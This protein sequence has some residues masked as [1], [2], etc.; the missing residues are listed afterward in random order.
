[1]PGFLSSTNSKINLFSDQRQLVSK[2]IDR[3]DL[4]VQQYTI[5]KFLQDKIIYGDPN[6]IFLIEGVVFNYNVLL[7]E[8]KTADKIELIKEMYGKEGDAFCN[9][10][11]G[12]FS[13]LFYDIN[14]K[15]LI[16]FTDHIGDKPIFY[17]E[18][19][20]DLY[21]GS[22]IKFVTHMLRQTGA[23]IELNETAAY[24][25]LTFGY[26]IEEMTYVD[27]VNRLLGGNYLV[28]Q[29]GKLSVYTYFQFEYKPNYQLSKKDII[30]RLDQLFA[31]S[32]QAQV[33]K[34]AEYGYQNWTS[35]SAGLD[36]RMT[37]YALERIVGKEF[38][39]YTYSPIGFAD[40]KTSGNIGGQL[41]YGHYVH[42]ANYI[43][44]LLK[45]IDESIYENEG[46]YMYFGA[47]VLKDFFEILNKTNIGV[48]HTGQIGDV[49]VG[50]FANQGDE[51]ISTLKG[52][53]LHS[54]RL[55]KSF[56]AKYD[57][58]GLLKKY[59]GRE[60]FSFYNRG[61]NGVNSGANPVLQNFTETYSPFCNVEFIAFCFSIPYEI[62]RNKILYDQWIVTKYPKAA[63]FR[64]NGVRL[65]G[66][67]NLNKIIITINKV[68]RK[69][70]K[71][72]FENA[73]AINSVTPIN[74]WSLNP[75]TAKAMD[76][77]F[78]SHIHKMNDYPQ[79]KED[80]VELYKNGNPLECN[81]V[82]TLLGAYNLLIRK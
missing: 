3:E 58:D 34:N 70:K 60:L 10:F 29:Y 8:Y 52:Y 4:F 14:A 36:S 20:G 32:V 73:T 74:I 35:L 17:A 75:S 15:K 56:Y 37:T 61:F 65:I 55:A 76:D 26:M 41:Q 22:E 69:L 13:G 18:N 53:D 54:K 24:S 27:N 6:Y 39:S 1:M 81:Q 28:F 23:S 67:P 12:S 44:S 9:K 43:G 78:N 21:V 2:S 19:G 57:I 82:L 48:I 66:K 49:I 31:A 68:Q 46:L 45:N 5:N 71:L 63:R 16:V 51:T 59:K 33:D 7:K 50:T 25:S 62:R 77:Y 30:D 79:L 80:M 42:M 72:F 40:H 11:R 64:H 38:Y 47:A